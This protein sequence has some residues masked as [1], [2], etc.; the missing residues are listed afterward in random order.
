MFFIVNR[1]KLLLK[2]NLRYY[3]TQCLCLLLFL[4]SIGGTYPKQRF[5]GF[6]L[7]AVP[8]NARDESTTIGTFQVR[9]GIISFRTITYSHISKGYNII[10]VILDDYI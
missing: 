8:Q 3:F 4:V 10:A 2:I 6:R 9:D 1:Q 7:V 5:I